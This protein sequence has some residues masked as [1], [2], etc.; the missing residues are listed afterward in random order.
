MELKDINLF[1]S[2][3]KNQID[4]SIF[5]KKSNFYFKL[6]GFSLFISIFVFV[7]TSVFQSSLNPM[8]ISTIQGLSLISITG[9][10]FKFKEIIKDYEKGASIFEDIF[11]WYL[12]STFVG[13][14]ILAVISVFTILFIDFV[15]TYTGITPSLESLFLIPCFFSVFFSFSYFSW[16][17]FSIYKFI[18]NKKYI[19]TNNENYKK[20]IFYLKKKT[21]TIEDIEYL[22]NISED[23]SYDALLL[24]LKIEQ[25]K[26]LKI[27]NYNNINE[28]KIKKYEKNKNNVELIIENY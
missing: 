20:A 6:L 28:Y 18:N 22:I 15:I 14:F 4:K 1:L 11:S 27:K 24:L 16:Q 7:L 17:Y 23:K 19:E 2:K 25:K 5:Y 12:Y 10:L 21:K 3:K 13:A 8:S 26:L 9:C